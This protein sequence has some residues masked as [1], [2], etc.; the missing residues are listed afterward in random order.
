MTKPQRLLPVRNVRLL[1][2]RYS[3]FDLAHELGRE[4]ELLEAIA[5]ALTA[6]SAA[7]VERQ[8]TAEM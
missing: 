6:W 7:F 5:P 4:G 8:L 3:A 1:R 2:N